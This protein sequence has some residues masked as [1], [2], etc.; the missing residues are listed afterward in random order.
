MTKIQ[1]GFTLIELMVVVVIVAIL[2]AVAYPSYQSAVLK[3]RRTDARGALMSLLQAQEKFRANCNQYAR[4]L[5]GASSCDGASSTLAY[6]NTS[7]ERLYDITIMTADERS[8]TARA[9]AKVGGPQVRDTG[10][11]TMTLT[12]TAGTVA[13][14]PTQCW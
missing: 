4:Q 14:T 10:C 2:A 8:F 1:R 5:S 9:T 11:S 3:G 13:T 6:S 12:L 7:S